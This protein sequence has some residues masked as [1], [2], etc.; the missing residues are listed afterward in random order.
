MLIM[1][2]CFVL[3]LNSKLNYKLKLTAFDFQFFN[4][5]NNND[6]YI[7]LICW[8]PFVIQGSFYGLAEILIQS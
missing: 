2:N 3:N 8:K 4:G 6:Y 1:F 5:Y 7:L